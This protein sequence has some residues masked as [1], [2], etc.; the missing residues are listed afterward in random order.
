[1]DRRDKLREFVEIARE[2]RFGDG[3]GIELGN[4][5]GGRRR[6]RAVDPIELWLAFPHVALEALADIDLGK[7]GDVVEDGARIHPS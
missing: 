3:L 6:G 4:P 7:A 1:V 5:L 2:T